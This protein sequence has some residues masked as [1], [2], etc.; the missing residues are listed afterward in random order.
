MTNRCRNGRAN[1]PPDQMG[2]AFIFLLYHGDIDRKQKLERQVPGGSD[3]REKTNCLLV[4]DIGARGL[5]H[6]AEKRSD[7]F[8]AE[9]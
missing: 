1:S 3:S 6:S 4:C 5:F 2:A 7:S 9:E 8:A